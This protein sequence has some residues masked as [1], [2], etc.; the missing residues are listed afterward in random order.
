MRSH[1]APGLQHDQQALHLIL[2][3]VV[4]QE[5]NAL[6]QRARRLARHACDLAFAD[7]M[8][9]SAVNRVH[10]LLEAVFRVRPRDLRRTPAA[11]SRTAQ[12]AAVSC[13]AWPFFKALA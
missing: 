9:L 4:Q 6:A 7:D 8:N 1:I 3:T 10:R 5:M 12:T 13:S 2:R 11:F